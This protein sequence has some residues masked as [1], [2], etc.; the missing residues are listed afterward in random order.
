MSPE[1]AIVGLFFTQS[2]VFSFGVLVL[3]IVNGRKNRGFSHPNHKLNLLGHAWWLSN[4]GRP[5]EVINEKGRCSCNVSQ[6]LRSLQLGLLCV[7]QSPKDRPSML[8][9]EISLPQPKKPGFFAKR[10]LV[11]DDYSFSNNLDTPST[12]SLSIT[13]LEP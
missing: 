1:Y 8:T 9:S 3:E 5:L 2:D 7:Q 4:E 10:N 12:N 13:I 6:V 11:D